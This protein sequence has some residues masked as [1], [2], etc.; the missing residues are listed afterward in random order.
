MDAT[1]SPVPPSS[2]AVGMFACVAADDHAAVVLR[3]LWERIDAQ[4]WDRLAD[5]LHPDFRSRY[6]HTGEV[7]DRAGYVA[8][9]RDYPGRWRVHVDD[10]VSSGW[11]AVTRTTVTDG[12]TTF[13]VAS[14]GEVRDAGVVELVEVWAD[15]EATPPPHRRPPQPTGH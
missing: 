14:F 12:S 10:V 15:S 9:N 7:L 11:R 5:L 13:H 1:A 8:V 3:S 2:A 4:A 6:V